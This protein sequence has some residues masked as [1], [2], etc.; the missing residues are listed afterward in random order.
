MNVHSFEHPRPGSRHQALPEAGPAHALPPGDVVVTEAVAGRSRPPRSV[1]DIIVHRRALILGFAGTVLAAVALWSYTTPPTFEATTTLQIDPERPRV[2]AFTDMAPQEELYNERV[3]DAY[4]GTQ[5]ERLTSR[6]LLAR[7]ERQLGLD[8]HPAFSQARGRG[9]LLLAGLGRLWP[10]FEW[11]AERAPGLRFAGLEHYVDVAPVKRSR[12]VRITARLPEAQLA[13]DV[14]NGVANEYITATA[15][16]RRQASE[17][18]SRWLEGQL[19]GLRK[20]SE[21]S[22]DEIQRFVQAHKLVP[23]QD[24]KLQFVLQQLEEQSRAYTEAESDRVQKEARFRMLA[25]ADPQTAAS[26][27]GSEVLRDLKTDLARLEREVS[28]ARTVYGPQHPK[29]LEL[30]ADL[31]N[32]RA[33]LDT[34]IAK[35]RAAV[36]QEYLAAVRRASEL[37]RRLDAQRETAIQQHAREMQLQLLRKEAEAN[38]TIYGDLMKRL[39]ELELAAQLRVTNV[40]VIDPAERPTVPVSPKHGRDLALALVGGLLGGLGL[41]FV[42]ELGDNTLRTAREADLM[43]QLPSVGTVPAMRGYSRRALPP[44]DDLPVRALPGETLRWPEQ[45]AGEAFRS[46]RAMVLKRTPAA[47]RTLLVTSA[48]PSEGKSFISVNLAVA[49]AETGRP[50]LLVDADF[51]RPVCHH[52]FGLDLPSTGLS[53]LLYRGLAPESVVVPS[54]VPNLAFLPAGPRPADPAALLSSERVV[55]LLDR[56][57]ERY[58][59]IVIDSP[60]VLAASDA[61]VLASSVDGVLLVVRAHATPVDAV[62]LARERLEALGARILGVVLNDVRLARNRYFYANYA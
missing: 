49:L 34:E 2:V 14:A 47:P 21:E 24:G 11:A 8:R 53:T 44:V 6:T 26:V 46:I 36:E 3:F 16:E 12:L 33:R 54:G 17:A 9:Q 58:H 61:A 60:P 38:E 29:M 56:A 22:S 57:A 23:T 28:R 1:V 15:V 10:G 52:A 5:F 59:W 51:R 41:A 55:E 30:E 40:K 32:A 25:T 39:K 42:R 31:A 13:A 43:I 7:V 35:G 50:V 48:Q 20:R 45:V 19:T 18:A 62:Q 27:I 37:G 4:Y